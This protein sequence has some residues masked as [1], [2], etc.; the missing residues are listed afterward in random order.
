MQKDVVL[1]NLLP[2]P[3]GCLLLLLEMVAPPLTLKGVTKPCWLLQLGDHALEVVA[4][5]RRDLAQSV[6]GL[7]CSSRNPSCQNQ[8][9]SL[10]LPLLCLRFVNVR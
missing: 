8:V 10:D 6:A 5:T 1:P 9:F 3:A 4:F 7:A 2:L